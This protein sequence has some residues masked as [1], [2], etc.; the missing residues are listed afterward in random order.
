MI[1]KKINLKK[2]T[3]DLF[4]DVTNWYV[5]RKP[6]IP[7]YTWQKAADNKTFR[8]TDGLTIKAD[9]SNV[10]PTSVKDDEASVIPTPELIV[11]F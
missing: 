8:T 3:I 4:L 7:E 6:V 1:D 10:I 2:I 9:G 5:A 11:E